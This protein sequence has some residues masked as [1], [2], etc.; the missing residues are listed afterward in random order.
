MLLPGSLQPGW[1]RQSGRAARLRFSASPGVCF[2]SPAA[3]TVQFCLVPHH[4]NRD[5]RAVRLMRRYMAAADCQKVCGSCG[6]AG[7][8]I[9]LCLGCLSWC[10]EHEAPKFFVQGRTRDFAKAACSP[11]ERLS[12]A[13]RLPRFE[14]DDLVRCRA[15]SEFPPRWIAG[16][17]PA[18]R[19][20]SVWVISSASACKS[21]P[22]IVMSSAR[23]LIVAVSGHQHSQSNSPRKVL[24]YP[25][26]GPAFRGSAS[27]LEWSK[28]HCRKKQAETGLCVAF[29]LSSPCKINRLREFPATDRETLPGTKRQSPAL[30]GPFGFP[31]YELFQSAKSHRSGGACVV[32][33]AARSTGVDKVGPW[34]GQEHGLFPT[35]CR[36]RLSS[37]DD[38][39][40][41][42]LKT[43]PDQRKFPSDKMSAS[44][45]QRQLAN[46]GDTSLKFAFPCFDFQRT[47]PGFAFGQS[48]NLIRHDRLIPALLSRHFQSWSGYP[49]GILS[50]RDIL[51]FCC[52]GLSGWLFWLFR[53]FQ[54]QIRFRRPRRFSEDVRD[55]HPAVQLPLKTFRDAP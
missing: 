43:V 32:G 9:G 13:A 34:I 16:R 26:Q 49:A 12:L 55:N 45:D 10:V 35:T 33:N 48:E 27:V 25:L 11:A 41:S 39:I 31:R 30:S 51:W 18:E 20:P 38:M 22:A 24:R 29:E 53:L 14:T 7:G 21:A 36:G 46:S 3:R 17:S 19:T 37:Q 2:L 28:R 52:F 54:S 42:R 40:G 6:S 5:T 50:H 1:V 23:T 44:A 4:R 47:A 15:A 8:A